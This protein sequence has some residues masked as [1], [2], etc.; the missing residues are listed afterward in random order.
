MR[1]FR[2]HTAKARLTLWNVSVLAMVLLALGSIVRLSVQRNLTASV[3]RDLANRVHRLERVWGRRREARRE[4]DD[5]REAPTGRPLSPASASSSRSAPPSEGEAASEKRRSEG[6][7]SSSR[8]RPR[9]LDMQGRPMSPGGE[10]PWDRR[11][12]GSA[13]RGHEVFAT[14]N[15]AGES[16]RVVS[17]PLRRRQQIVGVVQE[18]YPLADVERALSNLNRT[19]LTLIPVA[20]AAAWMGGM[21]LTGRMLRPV[22][23]VTQT[24][25]RIGAEDLSQ[26]LPVNGHD[27]FSELA[28]TFN[29]MLGRLQRAF[30]QQSRFTADASHE[31][32]TPLTV[33]KA[34]TSLALSQGD[35]PGKQR[36][37]LEAVD[38]ASGM[39]SRIVQDLLLLTRS[40]AGEL[41]LTLRP[42]QIQ[43]V[44]EAATECVQPQGGAI[45]ENTISDPALAVQGDIG[46]LTRLFV[47]LLDNAIRHTPPEGRITLSAWKEGPAVVIIVMDTGIGIPPEHLPHVCERFYRV[48]AARTRAQGGTGLGL[49]ICQSIVRAHGGS[50]DI[51]SAPEIGTTVR[52]S[53]P[54]AKPTGA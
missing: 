4:E 11:A 16:V 48:D 28:V 44:L 1:L 20:L 7:G 21:F 35:L 8:W 38:K 19:L 51:T 25:A 9:M 26:R 54:L 40:D 46:P 2:L 43:E 17:A 32:R 41:E 3:D 52:V 39:M 37:V 49:A 13:V 12:F 50:L 31:L 47:N 30:D 22:R 23:E 34:N 24:A 33:I 36:Q 53:L 29:E 18:G 15:A 5:R 6:D 10:A 14:V 27:E 45:I 42:T